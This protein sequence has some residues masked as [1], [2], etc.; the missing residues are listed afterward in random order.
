MYSKENCYQFKINIQ[1]TDEKT[2]WNALFA[3]IVI[4]KVSRNAECTIA[5][6]SE[7]GSDEIIKHITNQSF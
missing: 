5:V 6:L 2:E 4:K 7:R 3:K 1:L